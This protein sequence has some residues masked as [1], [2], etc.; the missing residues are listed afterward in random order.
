MNEDLYIPPHSVEAEQS[1]IGSLL[2]DNRVMDDIGDVLIE[3][4][5]YRDDHRR[6][7][8]H[9]RR[10]IESSKPA[11]V[12]T[13][14]ESIENNNEVEQAGGFQ[15]LAT[16]A[17]GGFS[18]RNAK[19]YA[20]MIVEQRMLRDL[21]GAV[22]QIEGIAY[23]RGNDSAADRIDRAQSLLMGLGEAD[24]GKSQPKQMDT[25][26]SG[27]IDDLQRRYDGE[28]PIAGLSTGFDD[29]DRIT[30]GLTDGDLII[31]AGRPS[32]GKTTLALNIAENAAMNGETALV[33][34]FEMGDK[35][36]ATRSLSS[37]GG[38]SMERIRSGRLIDSDWD[39]ITVGLSKLNK[40]PLI[41]DES[42]SLSVSQMRTR[43]NRVKRQKGLSLVVIDYLQLMEGQDKRGNRNEDLSQITRGLKLM[44]KD[45]ACPVILLS[46]L[47]RKCEERADKRP[48]MSDLRESGA[49]EQDADAIMMLYR[50]EQYNKDS[51][52]KGFAEC[53]IRKQRMG[54]TGVVNLVFQGEYSRFRNADRDAVAD[55]HRR[56]HDSRPMKRSRG[57]E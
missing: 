40:T 49:I 38:V 53:I 23:A 16:L 9:I 20:E 24:R 27:V 36:L 1:I 52:F 18:M 8:G 21:V 7:Y 12:I 55:A 48:I 26:L 22:T 43:A 45:L 54:E 39:N 41:I 57:M 34:S 44:A 42:S 2:M 17:N 14:S 13:V 35:Q 3:S 33:F 19:R 46:Q 11:D 37:V 25:V 6:I 10:L 30:C 31:L 56:A 5:F 32:M 51:Q 29:L 4:D 47:S 28:S 50:D 15:M